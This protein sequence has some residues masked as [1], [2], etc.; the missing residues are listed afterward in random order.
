MDEDGE[1]RELTTTSHLSNTKFSVFSRV[2]GLLSCQNKIAPD[3]VLDILEVQEALKTVQVKPSEY[4]EWL[5][6][7]AELD[8][9]ENAKPLSMR[10]HNFGDE[11]GAWKLR[12]YA[13]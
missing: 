11:T 1:D 2:I 4:I 5:K 7:V 10:F 9:E 12:R 6:I 3:H 13:E 8:L